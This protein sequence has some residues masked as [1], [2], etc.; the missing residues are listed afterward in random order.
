MNENQD[1]R[2]ERVERYI[3]MDQPTPA[4]ALL[5]SILGR[6]PDDVRAHLV[7][8]GLEIAEGHI[9]AATRHAL[10]AAR[11]LPDEADAIGSVIAALMQVGEIVEARR[12]LDHPCIGKSESP[13]VLMRSAAQRQMLGEHET[14]L[15][16]IERAGRFGASGPDFQFYRAVQL[17]FNGR[18][19]EAEADLESCILADPPLGRAFLQLSRMRTQTPERNHLPRIEQALTRAEPG[20]ENEA[21]LEFARYKELEDIGRHT[22]AWEAL[23]RANR[24]MYRRLAHDP[25][26]EAAILG[27]LAQVDLG[28]PTDAVELSLAGPQPIFVIGLPRSGTTVLD[29]ILGNHSQV[30]SAGELGDFARLLI[31]ATDHC[32]TVVPD[33]VIVDRLGRVDWRELG[34]LY[35]EQTQW[36]ARGR[37]FFIDKLPRNWMVAGLIHRAFPRAPIVNVVRDPMDVC[38]SNYRALFGDAYPYS[39]DLDA[40]AQHHRQYK[41]LMGR[42]HEAFPGAILDVDYARLVREPEGV[43]REVFAFCRLDFEA[44][45]TDLKRNTATVATLSM[46]QVRQPIHARAFGEWRPYAEQ[47]T[48]LRN[49]LSK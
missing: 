11:D 45:C 42:W 14:S 26:R 29:R 3:A 9:R 48:S 23:T 13:T 44:G 10:A 33:E 18:L 36:R 24:L 47:L 31:W 8:G 2:W 19:D 40:L 20:S 35:L 32:A 15:A 43:A 28:K 22:E 21:G 12:C 30:R 38:F 4:R 16:L 49:A 46:A 17:S 25:A 41:R 27:S 39:Y 5:E 6:N 34:R 37:P 7:M 1:K